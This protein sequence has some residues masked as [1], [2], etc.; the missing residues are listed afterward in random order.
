MTVQCSDSMTV[1][2]TVIGEYEILII[3]QYGVTVYSCKDIQYYDS[4]T[5]QNY[6]CTVSAVWPYHTMAGAKM[7]VAPGLVPD[8][9]LHTNNWLHILLP[10]A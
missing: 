10:P 2:C 6:N 8:G 5:L 1:Q 7:H 9:G 3:Q 4:I